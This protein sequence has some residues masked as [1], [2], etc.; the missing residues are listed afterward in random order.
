MALEPCPFCGA[1]GHMHVTQ[2]PALYASNEAELP[3]DCRIL[4]RWDRRGSNP[5][6]VVMYCR[7]IYIPQC[8]NRHCIGRLRKQYRTRRE[9]EEAWNRRVCE[10]G[11]QV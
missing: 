9:A 6:P 3:E 10:T 4:R 8:S 5:V 2:S 7:K 1:E 11:R